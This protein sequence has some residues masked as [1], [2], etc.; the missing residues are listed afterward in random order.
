MHVAGLIGGDRTEMKGVAP[1]VTFVSL[2]V[3]DNSGIGKTSNVIK[4][5]QWAIYYKDVYD[6]DIINLSLGH[7]IY[8]P[9]ASDPLVQAV[10]AAVRAGI[11]VVTSAGNYGSHP[12]TGEV[13]YAGISSPGNAPSAITVG[14]VRTFDTTSRTDDVVAEYSSRGPTWYDGYLKPDVV[15][16]GHALV[17]AAL[18]TQT[19]YL[20]LTTSRKTINGR[21]YLALS[22]TS[23]STAV[24][25]GSV[26]LMIEEARANYGD[27]PTPNAIKAMLQVSAFPMSDAAGTPYHLLAQ[28]AGGLNTIGAMSLA[29]AINPTAPVNSNWLR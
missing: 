8:E 10:E 21:P 25:S 3:L 24:V 26:A 22:G 7:P 17:S 19:L 5:L 15:A 23:M 12:D 11:V 9:A 28:G 29:S 18:T 1:G 6:I 14:A 16:P 27:A 13:G 4:A 2:K 20:S